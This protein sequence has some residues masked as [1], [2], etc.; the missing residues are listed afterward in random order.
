[1]SKLIT[2]TYLVICLL[3]PIYYLYLYK[4]NVK[5]PNWKKAFIIAISLYIVLV[6]VKL[7][8]YFANFETLN[9]YI[10]NKCSNTTTKENISTTTTTTTTKVIVDNSKYKAIPL[11]EGKQEI[12]GKTSKGYDIVKIN[13]LTYINNLLI[14]N[15]TYLLTS[16]YYPKDTHEEVTSKNLTGLNTCKECIINQAFDAWQDMVEAAKLDGISLRI[17]S[18]F[19]SYNCQEILYGNYVNQL[20]QTAAD[21]TSARAGSSEHQTG[22]AF[23]INSS[24]SSF[25]TTKEAKW[26]TSNAYK[27]GYI[28]RYPDKKEDITGY[29][30]EAWHYRYVGET[31]AKELYN[32]GNWITLEEYLGID[33]KYKN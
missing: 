20:G 27:F 14:A 8:A 33:S 25:N 15:K 19:R 26:L 1:M 10:N 18:G 23:D 9:C 24:S 32:D 28:L 7:I 29:E 13:G 21:L 17:V 5:R 11:P 22:L 31:L 2:Y 30:F 16:E 4:K 12:V 3:I 6:S